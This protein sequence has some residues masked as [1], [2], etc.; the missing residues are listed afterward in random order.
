MREEDEQR[1]RKKAEAEARAQRWAIPL[2]LR[3]AIIKV[4]LGLCGI[5]TDRE[6]HVKRTEDDPP[7]KPRAKLAA[8]RVIATYDKLSIDEHKVAIREIVAG[9]DSDRREMEMPKISSAVAT[10]CF[11]L[12]LNA[13]LAPPKPKPEPVPE[14]QAEL[15]IA[16]IVLKARW[17]LSVDVRR[18]RRGSN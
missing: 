2:A 16:E 7:P 9:R 4:K 1:A 6:G 5:E 17:P 13:P 18:R 11:G 10:E 8:M 3:G 12:I 14:I 15:D